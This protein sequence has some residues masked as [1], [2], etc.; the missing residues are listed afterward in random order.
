M[1]SSNSIAA[2]IQSYTNQYPDL[3]F[4]DTVTPAGASEGA[5]LRVR[6]REAGG[7]GG[8]G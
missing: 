1:A 5:Y 2:S 4:A 3:M 7:S 6:G 8:E